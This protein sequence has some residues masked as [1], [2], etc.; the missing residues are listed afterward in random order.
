MIIKNN[1]SVIQFFKVELQDSED[2]NSY[3][4]K[5]LSYNLSNIFFSRIAVDLVSQYF[6]SYS[7][8]QVCEL[9]IKLR[10]TAKN[11]ILC[12]LI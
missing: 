2:L 1:N 3:R 11:N 10:K 8:H 7:L 4:I 12:R 9:R 5:S 6:F